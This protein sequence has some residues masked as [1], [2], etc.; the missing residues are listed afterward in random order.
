MTIWHHKMI[1]YYIYVIVYN[2]YFHPLSKFPGPKLAAST[3]IPI[4]YVAWSGSLSYWV[5][6]LHDVYASDVVRIS[7]DELSFISGSAIK[8]IYYHRQGQR[9]FPKDLLTFGDHESII[10][11]NDADHSRFRRLLSHAFSDKALREQEPLVQSHVRKFIHKIRSHISNANRDDSAD[12]A[13]WAGYLAFDLIAHFSFGTS[14]NCLEDSRYHPYAKGTMDGL[15]LLVYVSVTSRFPPL[16]RLL[17]LCIPKS[18]LEAKQTRENYAKEQVDQRMAKE[19][20]SP[21]LF[22]YILKHNDEKGMNQ[23]EIYTNAAALIG[24]GSESTASLIVGATYLLISHPTAYRR[25]CFEVRDAFR[26]SEDIKLDAVLGLPY[27][28]AV[29]DESFRVY[30][31]ALGGLVRVVHPEGDHLCGYW[32][33]GTTKVMMNHFAAYHSSQNFRNPE[34]FLPERW[35]DEGKE[36][37][38]ADQKDVY[39]PFSV[40]ARN[41]IGKK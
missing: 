10:T 1:V 3:K 29:I 25:A 9:P 27:L 21:D 32:V 26:T 35:L 16:G 37:F 33:P 2:I 18:A 4:S 39:Q 34:S 19:T 30:P 12:L 36:E 20:S 13:A 24:A 6:S 22:S 15:R 14:F 40:G 28:Q 23:H 8:D 31:P 7:P 17:R 38:Q 41:C 11:A 5:K